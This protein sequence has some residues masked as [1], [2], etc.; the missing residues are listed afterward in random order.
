MTT[1]H[2]SATPIADTASDDSSPQPVRSP[3]GA[4][5]LAVLRL[6]TGF[7]F[8]WA[9]LDKLLGLNYSTPGER[10]WLSGGSPTSGFLGHVDVGPYQGAFRGMAGQAWADWGFMAA[11][12]AIGTAVTLGVG[13]R[14]AAASGVVLMLLMWAAEWP[15]AQFT[16]AGVANGSTNPLVDYHVIYALALVVVAATA[17]GDT[18]GVGRTWARLPLVSRRSWLR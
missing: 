3:W 15:P 16:S 18:W 9:F 1:I 13:L 5:S 14:I 11:L 17:A 8:L 6:A 7:V 2:R 12:A 10:A 4:R